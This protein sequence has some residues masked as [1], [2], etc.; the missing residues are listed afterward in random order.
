MATP[1]RDR[2][3]SA[4]RRATAPQGANPLHE[5]IALRAFEIWLEAGCPHGE[6]EEHWYRAE[7]E[8]R[9]KR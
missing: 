2:E 9:A 4:A 7:R 6:H 3:N 8:L 5:R 1:Q